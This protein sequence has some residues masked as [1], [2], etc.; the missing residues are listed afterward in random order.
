[1]AA[2]AGWAAAA[3][4][5]DAPVYTT[6]TGQRF[7]LDPTLRAV[8]LAPG[9]A[10]ELAFA[11]GTLEPLWLFVT[12]RAAA[13]SAL[14]IEDNAVRQ[15]LVEGVS[16]GARALLRDYTLSEVKPGE[17]DPTQR[18]FTFSFSAEGASLA[19]RMLAEP[20]RGP[21]WQAVRN[22]GQDDNLLRCLLAELLNGASA[23]EA[24]TLGQ[25]AIP[26]AISCRTSLERVQRFLDY[27]DQRAFAPSRWQLTALA[28]SNSAGLSVLWVVAPQARADEGK[29]L[30]QAL[31]AELARS[32]Q[33]SWLAAGR[34]LG[35]ALGALLAILTLGGGIAWVAARFTGASA[36]LCVAAPLAFLHASAVLGLCLGPADLTPALVQLAVYVLAS[37]CLFRPLQRWVAKHSGHSIV[38]GQAGLSSFEYSILFVLVLIGA[39]GLWR[40]LGPSLNG[41]VTST[42]SSAAT[43]TP[44]TSSSSVTPV[45]LQPTA[46]AQYAL[47][48]GA[49]V[50]QGYTPGGFIAPSP[51]PTSKPFELGRGLGQMGAGIVESVAGLGMIGATLGGYRTFINAMS[52]SSNPASEPPSSGGGSSDSD[53]GAPPSAAA[54]SKSVEA[55]EP[56]SKRRSHRF[57]LDGN[58]LHK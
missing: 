19:S 39:L 54:T 30:A 15:K 13:S 18:G 6:S 44:G 24:S 42:T 14:A 56:A 46:A 20:E 12:T 51:Y 38:P 35:V 9:S 7:S 43:I 26:A 48:I 21:T 27:V 49:G 22:A 2:V 11:D 4:A 31:T 50:L 37:V 53:S 34:T 3:P 40:E 36:T 47:G 16:S 32:Q 58:D 5:Q 33:R 23:V 25:K 55:S 8:S 41:A 29:K 10:A 1:M 45:K 52:M 28:A 17:L 57:G